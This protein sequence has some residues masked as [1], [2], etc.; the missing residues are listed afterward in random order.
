M[1]LLSPPDDYA[2]RREVSFQWNYDGPLAG[3]RLPQGY[4]FRIV[5]WRVDVR[6]S[7]VV[8]EQRDRLLI[9][10]GEPIPSPVPIVMVPAAL[11]PG[12]PYKWDVIIVGPGGFQTQPAAGWRLRYE[13]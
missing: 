6:N 4:S 1:T 3:G 2:A 10:A 5:A 8:S 12:V 7:E 11:E 9:L 13:P